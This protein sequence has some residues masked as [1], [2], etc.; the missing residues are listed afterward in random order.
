MR[1]SRQGPNLSHFFFADDSLV[2]SLVN[3]AEC[4]EIRKILQVYEGGS[5]HKRNLDKSAIFLLKLK[6]LT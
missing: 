2:F 4:I 3:A 5:G 6:L 1:A